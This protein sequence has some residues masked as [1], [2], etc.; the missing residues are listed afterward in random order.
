MSKVRSF[1]PLAE[2]F[3]PTKSN[4]G[5]TVGIV[6]DDMQ[7]S[8]AD[9]NSMLSVFS[10]QQVSY[11]VIAP[12]IGK[13]RSGVVTNESYVTTNS[14]FFD[15]VILGSVINSTATSGGS[16]TNATSRSN[17][18]TKL[19]TQQF[20]QEAFGHSKAVAALGDEGLMTL[21]SMGID[22]DPSTGLFQ[23]NASTVANDILTALSGP[24]R[25]PQR[26]PIDDPS[27]CQ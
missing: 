23:G 27:I 24:V 18:W 9:L 15:V 11:E 14:I 19:N 13:L 8:L 3:E 25:F 21:K 6:V 22:G 1:Y 12:Y 7:L 17:S 26:F 20:L 16:K 2:S 5:L 10:S 4:A